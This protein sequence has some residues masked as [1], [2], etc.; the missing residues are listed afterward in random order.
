MP[1]PQDRKPHQSL[2]PHPWVTRSRW[3][4]IAQREMSSGPRMGDEAPGD[5]AHTEGDQRA[6]LQAPDHGAATDATAAMA[7]LPGRGRWWRDRGPGGGLLASLTPHL[8]LTWGTARGPKTQNGAQRSRAICLRLCGGPRQP[9]P[10]GPTISGASS[11]DFKGSLVSTQNV[12]AG[13]HLG[14]TRL[15]GKLCAVLLFGFR[16]L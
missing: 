15:Q 6:D 16:T 14:G 1:G 8:A 11:P 7:S 9:P 3:G 4:S 10:E 5:E 13:G 12:A 2:L